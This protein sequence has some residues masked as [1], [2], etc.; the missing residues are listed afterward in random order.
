VTSDVFARLFA[1]VAPETFFAEHFE[2]Q[3]LHVARNDAAYFADV[4]GVAD[5]E[6]A[7]LVGAGRR[8]AFTLVKDGEAL[9]APAEP[10]VVLAQFDRGYT[11]IVSDATQFSPRLQQL[12]NRIGLR[13]GGFGVA[14]V[15]FTPS[16]A[17]GFDVHYDHHGTIVLQIEGRKRWQLYQP[18][19]E[20][21][22][23]ER[24]FTPAEVATLAPMGEVELAPGDT[25]YLP[26]GV[27]HAANAGPRSL[28]VTL[29]LR[30]ARAGDLLHVLVDRAIADD[31][32]LRRALPPMPPAWDQQPA[33]LAAFAERVRELAGR[34]T[35]DEIVRGAEVLRNARAASAR[36][37]VQGIFDGLEIGTLAPASQLRLRD[38][39][40]YALQSDGAR[41]TLRVADRSY[42]LPA[43]CGP[44]FAKLTAGMPF[45]DV[46]A[47]LGD[48][49]ASFVKLLALCGLIQ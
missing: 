14:N 48:D 17:R 21:P 43:S 12:C 49:A 7:L 36:W 28:H 27:P 1:P 44:L 18:T 22:V 39:A 40:P 24:L 34:W 3:P 33:F 16:G 35:A 9:A 31:V 45:L 10:H 42:A 8:D 6:D 15:Y 32:E 20:L 11:L 29:A 47:A 23:D 13:L 25:L 38:D 26:Q 46:Q 19:A 2:R 41:V 30:P 5:V 4:Y 37:S